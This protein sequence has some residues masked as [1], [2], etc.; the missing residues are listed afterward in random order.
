MCIHPYMLT[1]QSYSA[2]VVWI[3]QS[4]SATVVLISG[5]MK[6]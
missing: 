1:P 2:T 3:P 6:A 4:Y 5:M